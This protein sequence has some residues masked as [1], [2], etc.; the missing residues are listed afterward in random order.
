MKKKILKIMLLLFSLMAVKYVDSLLFFYFSQ[1]DLDKKIK[2]MVKERKD[3]IYYKKTYS[4]KKKKFVLVNNE[5]KKALII[6]TCW[7][8]TPPIIYEIE[9]KTS[10]KFLL[11]LLDKYVFVE[12]GKTM[13]NIYKTGRIQ[14]IKSCGKKYIIKSNIFSFSNRAVLRLFSNLNNNRGINSFNIKTGCA[15]GDSINKYLRFPYI[16]YF[17]LPF[18]AILILTGIFNKKEIRA[19][20]IYFFIMPVIFNFYEFLFKDHVVMLKLLTKL[21]IPLIVGIFIF[22]CF[23]A[24]IF[25]ELIKLKKKGVNIRDV[26][27][28]SIFIFFLFLPFVLRF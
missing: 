3:L 26:L 17:Y 27:N 13:I 4:L 11:P 19:S 18:F 7:K 2:I 24:F 5:D 15:F 20:Y 23:Y 16:F 8:L 22:V 9:N 10:G 12:K 14:I 25:R 28:S 1:K 6:K 21:N